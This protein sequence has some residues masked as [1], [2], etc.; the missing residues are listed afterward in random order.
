MLNLKEYR[1]FP[2]GVHTVLAL[3]YSVG[4]GLMLTKDGA[5]VAA[6]EL[7]GSDL[8]SMTLG[9]RNDL[10]ERLSTALNTYFKSG[11]V[12]SFELIRKECA[13][14]PEATLSA[15]PDPISLAIEQERAEDFRQE[16]N[17]YE[18]A[19]MFVARFKPQA[20]QHPWFRSF[21]Y[22]GKQELILDSL[23]SDIQHFER[24]MGNFADSL[25]SLLTFRRLREYAHVDP[26]G[27]EILRDDLLNYLHFTLTCEDYPV[28]KPLEATP[29][30][31]YL[32]AK[33][34]FPG[35]V[36]KVGEQYI[37][38]ISLINSPQFTYPNMLDTLSHFRLCYRWITRMIHMDQHEVLN[39]VKKRGKAFQQQ[40]KNA[41]KQIFKINTQETEN[42]DALNMRLDTMQVAADVH[43]GQYGFGFC[44]QT[45]ILF[46]ENKNALMQNARAVLRE[47]NSL[48]HSCQ[49][50]TLNAVEA[51]LGTIPG[52]IHQNVRKQ[53][54]HTGHL[55]NMVP[56]TT[57]WKGHSYCP[58]PLM[59]RGAE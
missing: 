47:I 43:N 54:T 23:E 30:E 36:L 32:C 21:F 51:W 41:T 8:A 11:W 33:D 28:N 39:V 26:F 56:L 1:T 22:T 35:D 12:T 25:S 46:N 55:A 59:N 37:V 9:Q 57:V 49:L 52:N 27:H 3:A 53:L 17:H 5:L 19:I 44:T 29:A 48:G 16:G 20:L 34:F 10:T 38:A 50:E 18:S 58:N 24:V 31:E 15:F 4:S 7:V 42:L 13:D 14:Y 2:E 45:L 6:F 40:E